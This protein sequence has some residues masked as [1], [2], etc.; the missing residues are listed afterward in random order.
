MRLM[1]VAFGLV[2]LVAGLVWNQYR[3]DGRE[4]TLAAIAGEIAGRPVK[5]RCQ[6]FPSQL[7]DVGWTSGEVEFDHGGRPMGETRLDRDVCEDIDRYPEQRAEASFA[8]VRVQR[9]CDRR[10]AKVAY[11]VHLLAHEAWHL[12]GVSDEAMTECYALQT[13]A[14]VAQRLGAPAVEAQA[15][16][17]W[18]LVEA[19]PMLPARYRSGHCRDG[20]PLDLRPN[21][22]VWP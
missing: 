8:C 15:L 7:L 16:A 17:A 2:V 10:T 13:T 1:A 12:R 19:Y 11:A 20:G 6:G 3:E 14:F 22:A 9:P 5:V 21:S 18:N 4:H